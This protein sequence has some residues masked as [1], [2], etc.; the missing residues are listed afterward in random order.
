MSVMNK[1]ALVKQTFGISDQ[2]FYYLNRKIADS[3]TDFYHLVKL[4]D[5]QKY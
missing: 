5:E 2:Q 4:L 1:K 3:T